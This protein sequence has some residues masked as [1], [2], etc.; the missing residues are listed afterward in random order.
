V[1]N[2]G[3]DIRVESRVQIS[4]HESFFQ[5]VGLATLAH[6]L[7]GFILE[8]FILLTP[9]LPHLLTAQFFILPSSLH[10]VAHIVVATVLKESLSM[11]FHFQ[12]VMLFNNQLLKLW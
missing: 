2:A 8:F 10:C 11:S 6:V 7:L 3:G 12:Q 5:Q 4:K 9:N 1:I